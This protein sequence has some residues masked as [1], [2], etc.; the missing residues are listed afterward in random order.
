MNLELQQRAV[1]YNTI[2]KRHN[3]LKIG[4]F[5]SMPVMESK[6]IENNVSNTNTSIDKSDF[7]FERTEETNNGL[8]DL[9]SGFG[10]S[11]VPQ[12]S[13]RQ[14]KSTKYDEIDLLGILDSNTPVTQ[15]IQTSQASENIFDLLDQRPQPDTQTNRSDDLDLFFNPT[16]SNDAKAK[17]ESFL[18]YDKNNF[19]ILFSLDR[20]DETNL[21]LLMNVVANNSSVVV[22]N[23]KFE[24]SVPKTFQLELSP[25]NSTVITAATSL[26]QT[27]HIK[28]KREKLRMRI[29]V[30]C[31]IGANAIKDQEE[32]S[33]FP[34]SFVK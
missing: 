4:L 29:R 13:V 9:T 24:A 3:Q 28:G 18:V 12:T 6:P 17:K 20:K 33:N 16:K 30:A 5:E 21:Y 11:E 19:K 14:S 23:F 1:E 15:T 34:E 2:F 26:S 10:T 8:L 22:S 31:N 32:I 25:P 27:I 7:R